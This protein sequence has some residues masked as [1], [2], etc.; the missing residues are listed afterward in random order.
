MT[1]R[2]T[3]IGGGAVGLQAAITL[4]DHGVDVTVLEREELGSGASGRA[5]GIC[6][7]AYAD[8]RDA[9]IAGESIQYFRT[10]GLLTGRPYLWFAR[11]GDDTADAIESQAA[12]MADHGRDVEILDCEAVAERFP[13]FVSEDIE[14]AAIASNA[15]YVDPEVYVAHLGD[16]ARSAGVSI[17]TTVPATVTEDGSVRTGDSIRV[18]DAVLVAAGAGTPAV[19]SSLESDLVLGLYRTQALEAASLDAA[20]PIYYDASTERYARPT[21]GGVLAGDGS[22][23]YRGKPT[24]YDRAADERFVSERLDGLDHRLR[25]DLTVERSWAGLCTA[26]P[27]RD[28]LLGE[29]ETDVFVA[30]GL[31]GHGL[32]RSPALG[33]IIAEQMLGDAPISGFDPNR[34]DGG[35]SVSLPLGVTD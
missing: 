33:R 27:D 35:E 14:T 16:R 20:I 7:D 22:E 34:F 11:E 8:R 5:A 31:C 32:M 28:P 30:T 13:G 4:A 17:Q 9:E 23:M 3:V 25:T 19:L 24:A 21:P 26:T 29:L 10:H 2:V 1:G 6:Y 15:G 12:R 18:S